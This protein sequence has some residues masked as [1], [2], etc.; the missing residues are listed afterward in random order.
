[1]ADPHDVAATKL[2]RREFARRPIDI[3]AADLRVS[4]GVA[5]VK[6]VLRPMKGA[7]AP[8]QEMLDHISK[9]LRGRGE[10]RDVII[11]CIIRGE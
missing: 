3:S 6:G 9:S 8:M 11:D 10:F 2:L 7:P 5:Y 4:H 1:M